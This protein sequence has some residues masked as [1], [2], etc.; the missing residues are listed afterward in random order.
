MKYE[1]K[2]CPFCGGEFDLNEKWNRDYMTQCQEEG[3][4]GFAIAANCSRC[5]LTIHLHDTDLINQFDQDEAIEKLAEKIN[6]R[7]SYEK[8]PTIYIAGA[9]TNDPDYKEKF[10]TAAAYFREKGYDVINPADTVLDEYAGYKDYIDHGLAQIMTADVVCSLAV[11]DGH[12]PSDGAGLE[13]RY[14]DT[15]GIPIIRSY[16]DSEKKEVTTG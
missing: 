1:L 3:R 8:H 14:A 10:A 16:Y 6:S 4:D 5:G 12:I 13:C 9:I 7:V 15:V 11:K 2:P